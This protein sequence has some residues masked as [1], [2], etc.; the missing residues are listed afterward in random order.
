[1]EEWK[2]LEAAERDMEAIN[3][4]AKSPLTAEQVYIFAVRLCDNEVDRDFE[5]FDNGALERLGQLLVGKSTSGAP[6]DRPPGFTG[7]RWSGSQP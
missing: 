1:M 6:G 5:R 4:L 3:R 2:G 7:R